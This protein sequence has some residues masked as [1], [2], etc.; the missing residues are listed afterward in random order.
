MAAIK[1]R[2]IHVLSRWYYELLQSQ[3]GSREVLRCSKCG[4]DFECGDSVYSFRVNG[5][6]KIY[7]LECWQSMFLIF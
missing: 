3:L 6:R 7:H 2:R 5:V 4:C 1:V